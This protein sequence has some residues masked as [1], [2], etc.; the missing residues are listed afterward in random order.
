MRKKL[1]ILGSG[2]DELQ[3]VE[4]ARKMG[5]YVIVTD[6]YSN[7]KDCPAK[8]KADEAWSISWSD[9]DALEQKCRIHD[10]DGVLSGFSE[11]KVEKNIELCARL[12]LPC[13]STMD[14]LETTRDKE[15]FK[16]LC[17]LYNVPL[18]RE[19][20]SIEECICADKY[21][22]I[23]KPVDR[24]GS[25]GI[26]IAHNKQEL[27]RCYDEALESSIT[28]NVVIEEFMSDCQKVDGMYVIHGGKVRLLGTSD[29]IDSRKYY[30]DRI[31]PLGWKFPSKYHGEY[32]EKIDNNVKKMIEGMGIQYGYMAISFFYSKSGEFAVFETA[33]RLS[34]GHSYTCY[35]NWYNYDYMDMLIE[36]ALSGSCSQH[37]ENVDEVP[38]NQMFELILH[39]EDGNVENIIGKDKVLRIP[40]VLQFIQ[41]IEEG[42]IIKNSALTLQTALKCIY[43]AKDIETLLSVLHNINSCY[44]VKNEQDENIISEYLEDNK[45]Y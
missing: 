33:F 19:Y 5:A 7:W 26:R 3:I 30:G 21:P 28:N 38:K 31:A 45:W 6:Y 2:K 36:V 35:K 20:N 16:K 22:V 23:I 41:Y 29:T 32:V 39:C 17:K 25:I 13:Y 37:I 10:V 18:V 27:R 4:H 12:H 44:K 8:A 14:Q 1:L 15:K 40:N 24:G 42:D 9:V 43:M 34:G 11:I